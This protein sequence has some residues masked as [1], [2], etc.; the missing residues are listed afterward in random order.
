M[1]KYIEITHS[2]SNEDGIYEIELAYRN[3]RFRALFN[4]LEVR[5]T[6]VSECGCKWVEKRTALEVSNEKNIEINQEI[7]N[8]NLN[9]TK[10]GV[11]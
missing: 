6:Y 3:G 7:F 2:T 8:L 4:M 1:S 9:S 11:Y 10:W 5:K